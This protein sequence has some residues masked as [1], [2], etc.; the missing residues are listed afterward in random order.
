MQTKIQ[1]WG[2]SQGIRFPKTILKEVDINIGDDVNITVHAG[3]IVVEPVNKVRGR[4]DRGIRPAL[5]LRLALANLEGAEASLRAREEQLDDKPGMAL[6]LNNLGLIYGDLGRFDEFAVEHPLGGFR[7][8]C[9]RC[10]GL[11]RGGHYFLHGEYFQQ[12]LLR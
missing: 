12:F 11:D 9:V 2:N 4:Y 8:R 10:D 5:D 3:K 7:E 6:S 1:K